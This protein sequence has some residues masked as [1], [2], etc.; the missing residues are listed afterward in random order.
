MHAIFSACP[1]LRFARL[2]YRFEQ[3][4]SAAGGTADFTS[5]YHGGSQTGRRR[6]AFET[7]IFCRFRLR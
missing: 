3:V 1:G 2:S 6:E 4:I 5:N 7:T